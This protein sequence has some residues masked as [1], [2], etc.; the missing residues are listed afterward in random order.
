ME[1]RIGRLVLPVLGLA[2]GGGGALSAE[3]ALARTPGVLRAY[4]NPG[5]EMAYVEYDYAIT[6]PKQLAQAVAGAGLR[7][8][9]PVLR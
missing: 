1:R 5:T 4:V 9:E 7:A 2:C 3:R 6:S 8:G